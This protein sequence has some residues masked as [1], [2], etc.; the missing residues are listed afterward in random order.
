MVSSASVTGSK[1]VLAQEDYFKRIADMNL[2][3]SNNR[4]WNQQ[5]RN[6]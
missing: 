4:I 3:K 6:F 1:P 5:Q 2:K